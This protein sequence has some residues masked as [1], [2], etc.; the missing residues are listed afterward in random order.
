MEKEISWGFGR[1]RH[2]E[3]IVD[4][5]VTL[6]GG[7]GV[8]KLDDRDARVRDGLDVLHPDGLQDLPHLLHGLHR[9]L[10]VVAGLGELDADVEVVVVA[11]AEAVGT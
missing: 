2:R 11:E 5:D 6:C 4:G 3:L 7:V 1:G 8:L 9:Q 10:L